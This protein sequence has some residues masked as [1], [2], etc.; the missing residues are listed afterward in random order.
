MFSCC[1]DETMG[2][3][4]TGCFGE[5][6]EGIRYILEFE[7]DRGSIDRRRKSNTLSKPEA[8]GSFWQKKTIWRGSYKPEIN[9]V[10]SEPVSEMIAREQF[11]LAPERFIRQLRRAAVAGQAKASS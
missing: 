2:S 5:E 1:E 10:P 9:C 7:K 11:L 3:V 8:V 6:D 4:F